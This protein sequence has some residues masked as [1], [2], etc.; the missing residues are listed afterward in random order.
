MP[1]IQPASKAQ[2]IATELI[3]VYTF[4]HCIYANLNNDNKRKDIN[5]IINKDRRCQIY[6]RL[7]TI[8]QKN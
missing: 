8:T 5:H 2:P 6:P 3:D 1:L 4:I 7:F